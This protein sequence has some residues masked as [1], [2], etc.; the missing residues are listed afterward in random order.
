MDNPLDAVGVRVLGSLIEKEITTPDYYPLTLNALVTACN[1][2]SNRDPVLTLDEAT[3]ARSLEDL[4]RRSLVRGVHRSDSRAKRYRQALSES[5]HLHPA[6][7]AAMCVLMLRGAQTTGEIRTRTARLFEFVDLKH[8]EVTLQALMTLP[9]P[10]VGQL[11]RRPGQ[12]EV[13]YAH[14]LSG[15]P[16]AETT[17]LAPAVDV[18]EPDRVEAL[19]Q[20]VDALRAELAELRT[21]FEE[22]RRQFQ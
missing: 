15:E 3:V 16:S 9:T 18:V 20:A 1:Q 11:P 19:E 17:E 6:E 10:L 2:T 4:A 13:R 5:L 14:L 7:T 21:R 22:F 12:K 8:V